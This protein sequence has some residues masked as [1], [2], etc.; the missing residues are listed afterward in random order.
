M[1]DTQLLVASAKAAPA[2]ARA[3]Q[4]T[5]PAAPVAKAN[6]GGAA[7]AAPARDPQAAQAGAAKAAPSGAERHAPLPV[8]KP[9]AAEKKELGKESSKGVGRGNYG[10]MGLLSGFYTRHTNA[11]VVAQRWVF[12]TTCSLVSR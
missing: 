4:P 1:Q 12:G 6:A 7:P 9:A 5:K 3:K 11:D 10:E 8:E 2:A